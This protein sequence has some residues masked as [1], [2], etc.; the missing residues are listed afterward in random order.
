M[1]DLEGNL[2]ERM[3]DG[4]GWLVDEVG[5]WLV[6]DF[7]RGKMGERGWRR[8]EERVKI[9][10]AVLC[11][12]ACVHMPDYLEKLRVHIYCEVPLHSLLLSHQLHTLQSRIE[13]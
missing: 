12:L 5:G 3:D 6:G 2:V 7:D 4:L 1:R 8:G 9:W 11:V 10:E 13:E